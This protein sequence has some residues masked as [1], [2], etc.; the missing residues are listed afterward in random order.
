MGFGLSKDQQKGREPFE[1]KVF[2]DFDGVIVDARWYPNNQFN[3]GPALGVTIMNATEPSEKVQRNYY[4]MGKSITDYTISEDSMLFSSESQLNENSGL[5]R[6]TA[7]L[8]ALGVNFSDERFN[9]DGNVSANGFRGIKAHF[10]WAPETI[11]IGR[12]ED[13][14]T[15]EYERLTANKFLG[16]VDADKFADEYSAK[17]EGGTKPS[18][19]VKLEGVT[20][21][22]LEAAKDLLQVFCMDGAKSHTDILAYMKKQTEIATNANLMTALKDRAFLEGCGLKRDGS[23]YVS[24]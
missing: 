6:F 10:V 9:I 2:N 8:E 11:T 19:A 12:G 17:L 7:D 18:G 5:G 4:K 16:F 3:N 15:Q 22:L 20:P 14:K 1:K 13:A 24:L 23:K 21:E